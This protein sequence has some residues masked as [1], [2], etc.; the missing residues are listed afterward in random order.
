MLSYK[1]YTGQIIYDD[2]MKILH[3]EVLDTRDVITFQGKSVD[4]IEKAFRE[5]VED[6]LE[7]CSKRGEQP[8]KPFSGKFILR[9]S[10]KL[11]HKLYL[12]ANQAG[13]SLNR[14]VVE[15]LEEAE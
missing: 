13:K 3:G 6:Y 2:E 12:K 14:W 8:D 1:G 11:H 7:F 4:E 10:P 9:M 15:T 5:S